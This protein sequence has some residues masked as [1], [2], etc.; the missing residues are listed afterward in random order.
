MNTPSSVPHPASA[1]TAPLTAAGVRPQTRIALGAE[2]Q[3]NRDVGHRLKTASLHRP[4][5]TR[6]LPHA[7]GR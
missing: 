6:S 7:R 1:V 3:H 2:K 5:I 4:V